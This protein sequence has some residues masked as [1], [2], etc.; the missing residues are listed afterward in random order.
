MVLGG[1]EEFRE[2]LGGELTLTMLRG[3]G[4]G[5]EIHEVAVAR[6]LEAIS[7]LRQRHRQGQNIARAC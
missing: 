7:E 3:I 1:L 4:R 5:V 6:M 2:H